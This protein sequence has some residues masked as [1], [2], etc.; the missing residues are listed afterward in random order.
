MRRIRLDRT[1]SRAAI[2]AVIGEVEEKLGAMGA[3]RKSAIKTRLELEEVL[4]A[5]LGKFGEGGRFDVSCFLSFGKIRVRAAYEGN[6]FN[7]VEETSESE[8]LLMRLVA[9]ADSSPCWDWQNGVNVIELPVESARAPVSLTA[10]MLYALGAAALAGF[11]ALLLPPSPRSALVGFA[12]PAFGIL[13]DVI[14]GVAGPFIFLTIV[15]SV[16]A[17]GDLGA[18]GRAGLRLVG[19]V[20]GMFLAADVLG[21]VVARLFTD[22]GSTAVAAGGIGGLSSF[23]VKLVPRNLFSPFVEGNIPQILVLAVVLGLT[24]LAQGGRVTA[25]VRI[26]E[27]LKAILSEVMNAALRYL[28]PPMVFMCIFSMIASGRMA[29]LLSS[30]KIAALTVGTV[31]GYVAAVFAF[32][33]VRF[34]VSPRE[35]MGDVFPAALIGFT[36]SSPLAG[37]Q[38]ELQTLKRRFAVDGDFADFASSLV[39]PVTSFGYYT[40]L[41]VMMVC[42]AGF[43]GLAL[44]ASWLL[45]AVVLVAVAGL[46]TPPF[47]GT[48]GIVMGLLLTQLGLPADCVGLLIAIDMAVDYVSCFGNAILR[49]CI[50]RNV[51]ASVGLVKDGS[52]T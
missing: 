4:L 41:A 32:T 20:A 36:T 29:M 30:W 15:G 19:A 9:L 1:L 2:G 34:G 13:L 52:G 39:L 23:L 6:P 31:A 16:C 8:A 28:L 33:C 7:P 38:Q 51:A 17:V 48:A 49:L 14:K 35:L 22:P 50:I 10:M 46:S 45:S 40:E 18:F 11:A 26:C 43:Y 5:Y 42:M 3:Q 24:L 44:P 12:D 21:V 27:E 47:P 37:L 25:A